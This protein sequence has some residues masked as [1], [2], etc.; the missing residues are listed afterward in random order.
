MAD[1]VLVK[2]PQGSPGLLEIVIG[3]VFCF[4]EQRARDV[5][6]CEQARVRSNLAGSEQFGH[7]RPGNLAGIA[8]QGAVVEGAAHVEGPRARVIA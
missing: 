8:Q 1:A 7:R 4:G 6:I 3:E 5:L 2:G